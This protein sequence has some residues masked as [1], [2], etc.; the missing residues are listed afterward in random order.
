MTDHDDRWGGGAGDPVTPGP[1]ATVFHGASF[2][3]SEPNGDVRPRRAQGYFQDDTRLLSTWQLLVDDRE[4]E[5]LL[6]TSPSPSET[7]FVLRMPPRPGGSD[8]PLLVERHRRISSKLSDEVILRNLSLER[9]QVRVTLRVDADFAD[10]FAVKEGRVQPQ[11]RTV[12]AR[13]SGVLRD[14]R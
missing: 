5:L 10:V 11:R 2:C 14:P 12:S 4:P 6:R 8:T 9:V 7:R 1:N 13:P 3:L